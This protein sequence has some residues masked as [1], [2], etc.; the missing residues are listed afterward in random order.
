MYKLFCFLRNIGINLIDSVS[1]FESFKNLY[2]LKDSIKL[3]CWIYSMSLLRYHFQISRQVCIDLQTRH[4]PT[5]YSLYITA[6]NDLIQ[7]NYRSNS[8]LPNKFD[9]KFQGFLFE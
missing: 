4:P 2:L 8:P 6:E 1:N 3:A 9:A 7:V 5:L